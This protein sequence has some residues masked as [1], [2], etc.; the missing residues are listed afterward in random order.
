[1]SLGFDTTPTLG[2]PHT[3]GG[4]SWRW[5]GVGWEKFTLPI[6]FQAAVGQRYYETLV[7]T[8]PTPV[9]NTVGTLLTYL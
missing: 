1:M 3:V 5:N 8:A 9:T 7:T 2:D 4:K 6:T